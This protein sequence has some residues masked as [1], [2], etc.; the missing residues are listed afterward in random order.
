[1][2]TDVINLAE[3]MKSVSAISSVKTQKSMLAAVEMIVSIANG[4][5]VNDEDRDA[6]IEGLRESFRFSSHIKACYLM[7]LAI[8]VL[9]MS[10][11]HSIEDWEVPDSR[12]KRKAA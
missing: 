5:A 4:N 1:M 8:E 10:K 2:K 12:P 7:N 11:T 9:E 3:S 6:V